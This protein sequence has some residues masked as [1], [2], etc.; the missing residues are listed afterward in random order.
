MNQTG[1]GTEGWFGGWGI[2][3]R[4]R[5]A[6]WLEI[7]LPGLTAQDRV[8][9]L[10]PDG[11]GGAVALAGGHVFQVDPE[12]AVRTLPDPGSEGLV[13]LSV[14]PSGRVWVLADPEDD[15]AAAWIAH[16]LGIA[17]TRIGPRAIQALDLA[18]EGET[19]PPEWEGHDVWIAGVTPGVG[20]LRVETP[21]VELWLP[22]VRAK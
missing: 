16:P 14:S 9:A 1:E 10:G 5:G 20:R 21:T 3:V 7:P 22:S 12:G 19:R 13:D 2:V 15:P 11:R 17:G 8:L 4:F 18:F 6:E